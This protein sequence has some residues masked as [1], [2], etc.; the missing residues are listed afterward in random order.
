MCSCCNRY[1]LIVKKIY[2]NTERVKEK[3]REI[4]RQ[5]DVHHNGTH[6]AVWHNIIINITVQISK[7]SDRMMNDF[8]LFGASDEKTKKRYEKTIS[9][10]M[11]CI[12]VICSR[13]PSVLCSLDF[14]FPTISFSLV[15]LIEYLASYF[16]ALQCIY[17]GFVD[18]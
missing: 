17:F 2:W 1:P 15:F 8:G 5:K 16:H 4:W 12:P 10:S 13:M 11:V 6:V 14:F 18:I 7:P 3:E 9:S